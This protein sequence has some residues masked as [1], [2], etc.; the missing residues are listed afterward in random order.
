MI[1]AIDLGKIIPDKRIN[2]QVEKELKRIEKFMIKAKKKGYDYVDIDM[3]YWSDAVKN[4]IESQLR[5]NGYFMPFI[6]NNC[7]CHIMR[8]SLV[9]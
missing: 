7:N 8:I 9:Y 4:K 3:R 1:N 2:K 6:G 5:I